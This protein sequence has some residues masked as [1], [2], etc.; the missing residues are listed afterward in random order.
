MRGDSGLGVD[1]VFNVAP[2]SSPF[3]MPFRETRPI[4]VSRPVPT[5]R[6]ASEYSVATFNVKLSSS[7]VCSIVLRL[8]VL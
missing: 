6:M 8:R 3:L 1:R 7:G 2:W 4:V 5:N